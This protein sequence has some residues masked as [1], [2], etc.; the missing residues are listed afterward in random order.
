MLFQGMAEK[1]KSVR[2]MND[3]LP[4][5]SAKWHFFE[6]KCREIFTRYGYKEIRT[7]ILESTDLFCRGIGEAT[8]IV[9]KE[10]FSFH[11]LKQRPMTMRPEGTAA[12]V[13]SYIQHSVF[14]HEPVTRWFYSGP[15]FRYERVQAG[16]YRQFYQIG[17]EAYGV[18]EATVEAEQIAML[19]Q[20][21]SEIGIDNLTVLV[22]SVGT[23]ED[24]PLYRSALVAFATPFVEQLCGDCQRRLQKNPLRILDCKIK[25]CI[26]LLEEAPS[27]LDSLGPDSVKH[28]EEAQ[29]ALT[30]LNIPF[31][32]EPR[33][34]RGLDYY[35]GTVFEIVASTKSLGNQGTIVAGGRYDGLVEQLGGPSTPAVGFALG[36]ERAIISMEKPPA[37]YVQSPDVFIVTTGEKAARAKL[38]IAAELRSAGLY[39]EMEHRDMSMKSQFK[40]ANKMDAVFVVS[41]GDNELDQG[42]VK[43]K[44]MEKREESDVPISDLRDVL[45]GNR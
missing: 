38:T 8:D 9:E 44:H 25:S 18:A 3:L 6:S 41:I 24:R 29:E 4:P 14:N 40:R 2:G 22:N 21:Y 10:M 11:D 7:P 39:V 33:L 16:R 27:V 20:L 31:T 43:L 34:V 37:H 15:M 36:I 23:S 13:R 30:A 32:I 19:Y 45:T 28:F 5:D 26:A 17:C 1:L 42:I 35:T 12:C